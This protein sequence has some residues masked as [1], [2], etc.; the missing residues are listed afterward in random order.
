MAIVELATMKAKAGHAD[1]MSVGL[2]AGLSVIA[3]ADGCLG[4]KALR[5]IERPDEFVLRVEWVSVEAHEGF[6]EH[7]EFPRYRAAFSEH[8]DHVVGFAHYVEL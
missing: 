5:C 3:E 6:R 4:A 7:P 2:P 8:L 1:A